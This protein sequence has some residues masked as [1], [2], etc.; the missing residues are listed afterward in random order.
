MRKRE[1]KE[2]GGEDRKA[3]LLPCPA[4]P[5]P[6]RFPETLPSSTLLSAVS[7]PIDPP[8]L[9]S[10]IEPQISALYLAAPTTFPK[11]KQTLTSAHSCYLELDSAIH[12]AGG[13]G[14]QFTAPL[15]GM[16]GVN[17]PA[18]THHTHGEKPQAGAPGTESSFLLGPQHQPSGAIK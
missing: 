7:L 10:I 11:A 13:G 6:A 1:G 15:M 12:R 16:T 4:L 17:C 14:G 8:H 9:P 3:H 5:A 18:T 2:R